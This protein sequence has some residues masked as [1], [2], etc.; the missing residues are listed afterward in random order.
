MAGSMPRIPG[1]PEPW[2]SRAQI[3]LHMDVSERTID[4]WVKE[5]VPHE[6]WGLATRK[7]QASEVVAWAR[8]R[9]T[10]TR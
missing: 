3:A 6:T 7:F 5:G 9:S 8:Q 4:R 1:T 10:G 2:L